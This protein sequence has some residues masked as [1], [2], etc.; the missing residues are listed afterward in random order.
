M[1]PKSSFPR[2]DDRLVVTSLLVLRAHA[3]STGLLA[4]NTV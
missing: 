3:S 1:E 4:A 2:G